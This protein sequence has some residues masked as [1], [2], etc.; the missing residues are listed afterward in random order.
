MSSDLD[1]TTLNQLIPL[2]HVESSLSV[3]SDTSLLEASNAN[4]N[5]KILNRRKRNYSSSRISEFIDIIKKNAMIDFKTVHPI[6]KKCTADMFVMPTVSDY[7]CLLC[8]KYK[9]EQLKDIARYHKL[10]IS[11]TNQE[12]L[13]R[14]Y[15]H[16]KMSGI[17]I[18]IQCVFRGHL[19]R[20]CNHLRGD[21][22]MKRSLCTNQEDFLT[23][24]DM[25]DVDHQQFVSYS[26]KDGFVYGF[27]VISLYNLK[28]SCSQGEVIK[29]PYNRNPIPQRVFNNVKRLIKI[30]KKVYLSP[31]DIEIEKEDV[32]TLTIPERI[33]R[34]FMEM[35]S[36]GHYT[37]IDWF[38]SL[39]KS[40][41]IR[42]VQEMADIW[43][44]RASLTPEVRYTISPVDP[45]RT[46][47]LFLG[48]LRL[49]EDFEKVQDQ[50]LNVLESLVFSGIDSSARSLGILYVLQSFTLVNQNAR[51]TMPWLYEAVAYNPLQF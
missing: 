10:K 17:A 11:G 39:D 8:Y 49:E 9:K 16:L 24:E 29:N 38:A 43:Y 6:K 44:Y 40:K 31:L 4:C 51:D 34:V 26:D 25:Q 27:D 7:S 32:T 37:C 15:T 42:L 35:D 12:L 21:A 28:Q 5:N 48:Y 47:S 13:S 33:S 20:F 23:M 45:L 30:M 2:N 19:Q 14:V 3:S 22:F 46:Y 18:K 1:L 36:H 41:L 50:V